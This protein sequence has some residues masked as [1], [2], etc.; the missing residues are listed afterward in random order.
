[1]NIVYPPFNKTRGQY[2]TSKSLSDDIDTKN[3]MNITD[4]K[5]G[6]NIGPLA[7]ITPDGT[8]AER[9]SND[10]SNKITLPVISLVHSK[11]NEGS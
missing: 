7:R 4:E 1:M 2:P 9:I 10:N 8:G 5:T 3:M 6:F 11:D